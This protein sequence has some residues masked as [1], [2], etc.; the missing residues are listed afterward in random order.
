MRRV[1]AFFL[2]KLNFG[3]NVNLKPKGRRPI[4]NSRRGAEFLA[5]ERGIA[6]FPAGEISRGIAEFPAAAGETEFPA[7]ET[8]FLARA[9][10]SSLKCLSTGRETPE[11]LSQPVDP[12]GVGG[13]VVF[14]AVGLPL[15]IFF[16]NL[17]VPSH[18]A[19]LP[20]PLRFCLIN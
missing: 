15:Y 8:E 17:F 6:E 19:K 12:R 7:R 18:T 4:W 3:A 16:H 1:T 20:G 10:G 5:G 9:R 2:Q 14:G 13:S 11:R